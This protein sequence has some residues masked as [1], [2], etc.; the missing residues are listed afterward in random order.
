[1]HPRP[2]PDWHSVTKPRHCGPI[3]RGSGPISGGS[4]WDLRGMAGSLHNHQVPRTGIRSASRAPPLRRRWWRA[5]SRAVLAGRRRSSGDL[6]APWPDHAVAAAHPA[7]HLLVGLGVVEGL[8]PR[9]SDGNDLVLRA[10]AGFADPAHLGAP[11][12]FSLRVLPG[13]QVSNRCVTHPDDRRAPG[14]VLRHIASIRSCVRL[15]KESRGTHPGGHVRA[16]VRPGRPPWPPGRPG[17]GQC[18]RGPRRWA[19]G[20]GRCGR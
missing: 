19:S 11:R 10:A 18:G 15:V 9:R 2:P 3:I 13:Q 6:A 12:A 17:P 1:V 20:A 5:I 8:E 14:G 16:E 7:W 4:M